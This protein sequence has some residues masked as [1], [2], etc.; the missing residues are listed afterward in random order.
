MINQGQ[1]S[2]IRDQ[3]LVANEPVQLLEKVKFSMYLAT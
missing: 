3:F 1:V 2:S